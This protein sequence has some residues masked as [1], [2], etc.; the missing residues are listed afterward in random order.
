MNIIVGEEKANLVRDRHT[1]LPL[2]EILAEGKK[3]RAY[4]VITADNITLGDMPEMESMIELHKN[5]IQNLDRGNMD[6]V[7]DAIEHLK[8][9]FNG[10]LDS[11]YE[12]VLQRTK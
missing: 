10:E 2:E 11:F 1:V 3:V 8:G 7:R 6:Y 9:K 12:I 4:C 5:M